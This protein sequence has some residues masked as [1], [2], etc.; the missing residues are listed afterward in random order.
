MRV[1]SLCCYW[2]SLPPMHRHIAVIVQVWVPCHTFPHPLRLQEVLTFWAP[3]SVP[4]SV[5]HHHAG[6]EKSARGG[7]GPQEVYLSAASREA[8]ITPSKPW[9]MLVL[10][11]LLISMVH[12]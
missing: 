7:M 1:L 3:P 2:R 11:A 9:R 12:G 10:I 4:V 8:V 5:Q 6:Q